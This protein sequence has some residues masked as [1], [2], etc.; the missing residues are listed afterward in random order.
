MKSHKI[1]LLHENNGK[2]ISKQNITQ[3]KDMGLSQELKYNH[4]K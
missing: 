1:T 3:Y 2:S 4:Q